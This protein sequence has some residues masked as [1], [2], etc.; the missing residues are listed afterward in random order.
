MSA[1]NRKGTSGSYT[2]GILLFSAMGLIAAVVGGAWVSA[3]WGS[4]LAGIAAPPSHPIELVAGLLKGEVPWPVQATFI[5]AGIGAALVV[6]AVLIVL[7][8]ARSGKNRTRVDKAAVYMGRGKDLNHLSTKG[9]KATAERLGVVDSVGVPLGRT[10]NGKRPMW[11]S[12]E[13]M[14]IL[15]A[16]PRTMK[17]TSYAVPAILEAPGAVIATSNKRDIVDV[18][19]SIRSEVGEVWVFDPQGVAE[20]EPTWWWNPLSYVKDEATAAKLATHFFTGS[21]EPGAKPDA[22]FDTAGRNLLKSYLLAAA[23]DD[24]PITQVYTWLTKQADDRPAQILKEHAYP[25]LYDAVMSRLR[26]PDKERGS[27]FSTAMEMVSSLT[28]RNVGKWITPASGPHRP[29]FEPEMFVRAPSGIVHAP[30]WACRR[31]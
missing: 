23:L 16:G 2:E 12:W 27:V 30:V 11:A 14:L 21:R 26:A 22:F 3:H 29:E 20:E 9:A 28:D 25:M 13:D 7:L 10:V 17:T 24:Q 1:P 6:L 5:A 18:T 15:I 8:V 31:R 19:R 4:T